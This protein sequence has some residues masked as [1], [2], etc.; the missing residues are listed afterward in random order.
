MRTFEFFAQKLSNFSKFIVCS[1]GQ[2]T[3]SQFGLVWGTVFSDFVRTSFIE[4]R[5]ILVASENKD[6]H[7]LVPK[8][9]YKL[10]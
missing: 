7:L 3:L 5:F 10:K 8:L 2:G 6:N 1:H 9:H 4:S